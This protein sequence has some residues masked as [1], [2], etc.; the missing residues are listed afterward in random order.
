MKFR[1]LASVESW[2]LKF[3][4]ISVVSVVLL[5]CSMALFIVGC[6]LIFDSLKPCGS[7]NTYLGL[8]NCLHV[9]QYSYYESRVL[10]MGFSPDGQLIAAGGW[11]GELMIWNVDSGELLH[12]VDSLSVGIIDPVVYSPNGQTI[13]FAQDY[14]SDTVTLADPKSGSILFQLR[15][16]PSVGDVDYSPDGATFALVVADT[17]VELRQVPDGR[18]LRSFTVDANAPEVEKMA[19]S[20]DGQKL[21]AVGCDRSGCDLYSWRVND[22]V[23]VGKIT[24]GVK[25]NLGVAFSPGRD[26]LALGNCVQIEHI[27]CAK[28]E[29]TLWEVGSGRLLHRLDVPY[30]YIADLAFS[31]DEDV[32]AISGGGDDVQ[33]GSIQLWRVSDGTLLD[34]VGEHKGLLYRVEFSP[35]QKILAVGSEDVTLWKI[36]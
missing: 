29:V 25:H 28:A 35:D 3:W 36:K 1:Q 27:L 19:F 16:L 5:S 30:S 13:V 15:D 10:D 33:G 11:G 14:M 26:I 21:F 8:S 18:L 31:A 17:T 20:P 22:G 23:R 32:L 12:E 24:L 6:I 2:S 7:L 4:L 9:L 34:T